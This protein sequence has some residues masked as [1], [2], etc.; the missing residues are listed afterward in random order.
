MVDAR[1][2]F[3]ECVS[4]L[5]ESG[6]QDAAFEANVLFTHVTG[7][8]R[9]FVAK[10]DDSAAN[11]FLVA[12]KQRAK[13]VP[14]Q[15]ITGSWPFLELELTVGPGVLV[16]RP[17]TETLCRVAAGLI[18]SIPRP[19][20]L[21]LCAG[22]GAVGLGIQSLVPN[23]AATFVEKSPQA[24]Q[25]LQNNIT[26]CER[27]GTLCENSSFET[28]S[29]DVLD[30]ALPAKWPP[31][32]FDLLV[33]NPPYI[34][35]DEYKTLDTELFFEPKEALVADEN[36][37]LFYRAISRNYRPCL[38]PGGHIAFEIGASQAGAISA[39]LM[40]DE[41][42]DITITRDIFGNQRVITAINQG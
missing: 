11:A 29:A 16:P 22:T 12:C 35:A 3:S 13:H 38:A 1:Q 34:T 8:R 18:Q 25:Y 26:S 30:T 42:T 2:I 6:I 5:E 15:Y 19:A 10:L 14:L 37:L 36:G 40:A 28:L 9:M 17:E 31:A 21:D 7:A 33:A 39:I 41:Y 4:L 27:A 32:F 20:V 23:V 24:F